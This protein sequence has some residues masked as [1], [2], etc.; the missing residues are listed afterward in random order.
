MEQSNQDPISISILE[1]VQALE[2]IISITMD[3]YC[4]KNN[5]MEETDGEIDD[6]DK[7]KKGTQYDSQRGNQPSN[8]IIPDNV[9]KLIQTALEK[10]LKKLIGK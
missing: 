3:Y 4:F 6:A 9:D 8:K 5:M 2:K 10:N 1:E 7:W